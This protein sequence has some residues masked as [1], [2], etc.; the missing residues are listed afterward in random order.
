MQNADDEDAVFMEAIEEDVPLFFKSMEA[1]AN[2]VAW[3]AEQWIFRKQNGADLQCT[4]V[5]FRLSG[6][7]RL[8][9][10][11]ADSQQV[12]ASAA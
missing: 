5:A 11:S 2:L 7:P 10:V 6:A 12:C 4:E 3:S 1:G 8:Q 9:A